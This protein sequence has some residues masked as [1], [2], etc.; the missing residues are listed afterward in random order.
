M[1][2]DLGPRVAIWAAQNFIASEPDTELV[3]FGDENQLKH[4]Y[5]VSRDP[6]HQIHIV[7]CTERV[8]MD[9]N[10]LHAVRHKK[11]SSMYQ[12]LQALADNEVDAC[13][14][15]GNTGALLVMGKHL[16]GTINNIDRPA[17]CKSMPVRR[18]Q[19]LMLDLGANINCSAKQLHQFALMASLLVDSPETLEQI[20][21]S[22]GL[23]NIGT[24]LSKGTD[25]LQETY[26]LLNKDSRFR[27]TGFVEA[28]AIFSGDCDVIVCD[29]FHGNIAL[30]AS[31]GTARFI[32]DKI[33]STLKSGWFGRL[34]LILTWPFLKKLRR[35]LDPS[36][37]NGASFLGL[38]KILVKSHGDANQKAFLRAIKVAHE[39]ALSNIPQRISFYLGQ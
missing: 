30:K 20:P 9:D 33:Q 29:G 19:T 28:N 13:V 34:G 8:T 36:E 23:L 22:V 25:V 1:S 5:K 38:K 35:S 3:L 4:F 21:A 11:H 31:E 16:I 18:G 15:A 17:I 6:L 2:G 10:P 32:A 24:E 37:Y 39:Q 26:E 12:S 27:F 7:H 14:S